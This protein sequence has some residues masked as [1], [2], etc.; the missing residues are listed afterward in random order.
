MSDYH[1][2]DQSAKKDDARVVFHVAIPDTT[3]AAGVAYRTALVEWLGGAS[4]IGSAVFG[5]DPV[6]HGLTTG[7]IF[8]RQETVL[9]DG[10]LTPAQKKAIIE[11][12]YAALEAEIVT[13]VQTQLQFWGWAGDV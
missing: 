8:E 1:I 5:L 2:L 9:F 4:E 6:A 7:A 13:R 12:R 11:A 10:N 3:N